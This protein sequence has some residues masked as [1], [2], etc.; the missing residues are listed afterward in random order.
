MEVIG[1]GA[2]DDNEGLLVRLKSAN[3]KLQ[4]KFEEIEKPHITLS[5]S[6]KGKA[7]NTRFLDFKPIEK[8]FSFTMIYGGYK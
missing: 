3:P 1:Y 5:I 2:D 7:V 4:K 6:Q 8:P